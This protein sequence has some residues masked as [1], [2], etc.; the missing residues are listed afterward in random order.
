MEQMFLQVTFSEP[1]NSHVRWKCNSFLLTG[2]NPNERASL[3]VVD[4]LS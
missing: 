2:Q 1:L 4:E 3:H